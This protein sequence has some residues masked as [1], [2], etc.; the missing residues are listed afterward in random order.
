MNLPFRKPAAAAEAPTE[1][2]LDAR[3]ALANPLPNERL[4]L[5]ALPELVA[6]RDQI[7]TS[8][9]LVLPRAVTWRSRRVFRPLVLS[10]VLLL[11]AV[12]GIYG[13][14]SAHTGWFG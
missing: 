13:A 12:G 3:V 11:A 6:L 2:D 5:L 9:G 1:S 4:A 8:G 7:A 10:A 14:W